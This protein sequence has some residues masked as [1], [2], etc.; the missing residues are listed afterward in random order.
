MSEINFCPFCDAPQHKMLLCRESL[1]FC[2]ECSRFFRLEELGLKCPKCGSKNIIKSDFPS[3]NGDVA[4]QCRDCKKISPAT[5]LWKA[6][7]I[8]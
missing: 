1:F 7:K 8:R 5:E 4:F 6:N 2:R 3:P